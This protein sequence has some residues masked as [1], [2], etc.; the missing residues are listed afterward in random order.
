[1]KVADAGTSYQS[2]AA[3]EPLACSTLAPGR[4][5]LRKARP[6]VLQETRRKAATPGPLAFRSVAAPARRV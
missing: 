1:M 2:L 5:T 3:L 4:P 6:G